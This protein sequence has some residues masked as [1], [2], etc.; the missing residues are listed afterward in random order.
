M[1]PYCHWKKYFAVA[2]SLLM[3]MVIGFFSFS[4]SAQAEKKR[5]S[6]ETWS[7]STR[8][9]PAPQRAPSRGTQWSAP[10][11]KRPA[12]SRYRPSRSY[13]SRGQTF[14]VLPRDHRV[15]MHGHVRYYSAHGVWYRPYR[16]YYVVVA[17]PIGLFVP[18]LPFAYTT[19]WLHGIPYYYANETYYAHTPGGYV[20]VEPPQRPLDEEDPFGEGIDGFQDDRLFV[21]PRLN[22]SEEQQDFDRYECHR[23]AVEQTRYDPTKIPPDIPPD[24]MMDA[25]RDYRQEMMECL[26]SRGYTAR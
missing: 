6:K 24:R 8:Q 19:V 16:G 4:P 5:G 12:D 9:A 14:R 13:P 18:F 1:S 3:V 22:Q 23:W 7:K 17:P 11:Q 25:R 21:Y 15:F 2:L 10:Q 20:V 26:D